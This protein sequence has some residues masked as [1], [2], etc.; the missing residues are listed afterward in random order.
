MTNREVLK[1]KELKFIQLFSET[2]FDLKKREDCAVKAGYSPG[3]GGIIQSS[4]IIRKISANEALKKSLEK[5]GIT[6][7]RLA[8][9]LSE[10]LEAENPFKEGKPDNFIR[11]KAWESAIRVMDANPPQKLKIDKHETHE[12]IITD[13]I[14]ADEKKA[15]EIGGYV[16]AE[17]ISDGT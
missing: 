5:Q 4:K 12:F 14:L 6:F 15:E 7:D 2:G 1:E 8:E 16:D 11:H 13:E 9:K 10:L 3:M 17:V